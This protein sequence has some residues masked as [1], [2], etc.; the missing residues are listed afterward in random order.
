MIRKQH[1][2]C[3]TSGGA[4]GDTITSANA[5]D[6]SVSFGNIQF[7]AAGNYHVEITEVKFR[8]MLIRNMTYDKHTFSYDIA[9]TY[10]AA[11]GTLSAKVADGSQEGRRHLLIFTRRKMRRMLLIQKSR[12]RP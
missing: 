10:N 4:V 1:G 5:A 6:G 3:C 11:G 12:P 8:N 2:Q 7:K 9:V